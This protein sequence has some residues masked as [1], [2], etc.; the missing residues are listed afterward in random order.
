MNEEV[1]KK[2]YLNIATN[3]AIIITIIMLIIE[4]KTNR[5]RFF[6]LIFLSLA[7]FM[8]AFAQFKMNK[9][10]KSVRRIIFGLIFTLAGLANL[11]YVIFK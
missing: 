5:P 8:M 3:V 6:S 2:L 9:E 1:K 10:A 11:F 7:F 4:N